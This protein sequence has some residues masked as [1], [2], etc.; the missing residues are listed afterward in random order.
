M[1]HLRQT[2][3]VVEDEG[4]VRRTTVDALRELGYTVRHAGSAD[5]ALGILEE[6]PGITLLFTDI[7]MPGMTGR[8]LA[9]IV[10]GRRPGLKV[11]YTTGYTPHSIM[12]DGMLDPSVEVLMKPFGLEELARKVRS[13]LDAR[14]A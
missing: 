9:D 2:I 3:L 8:Q 4:N 1:S 12:R 14:A 13:V 7:M 10:V 5:E 11:L 6:Q